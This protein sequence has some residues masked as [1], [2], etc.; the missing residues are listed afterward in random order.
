MAERHLRARAG[1]KR[2]NP[3]PNVVKFD[4]AGIQILL[5][6]GFSVRELADIFLV[7]RPSIQRIIDKEKTPTLSHPGIAL[8]VNARVKELIETTTV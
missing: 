7:S 2:E 5:K 1:I 6:R 4:T 3:R 8:Y